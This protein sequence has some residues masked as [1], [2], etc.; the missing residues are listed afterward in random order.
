[1]LPFFYFCRVMGLPLVSANRMG[2]SVNWIF[3]IH[4]NDSMHG[5]LNLNKPAGLTS[6]D[7][8]ARLRKLLRQ[9]KIG[10]GGTLDPAAMGVLPIAIGKATRLLQ[11]L[12]HEK[13]YRATI[14][15]G[16]RTATDDLEGEVLSQQV[17]S[18]LTQE[19]VQSIL[20][21]FEGKIE[22]IPP[23]YSAIQVGG[24][25]LYELARAGEAIEAP[26]RTVEVYRIEVLDWRS[27]QFPELD[28]AIDCGTGTYIRSIARDLGEAVGTG[29]TLAKLLRTHSSGF[30]LA[31]SLT[32]E[33]VADLVAQTNQHEISSLPLISPSIALRHFPTVTLLPEQT[34]RWF[35][36]QRLLWHEIAH[37]IH[38]PSPEAEDAL[39]YQVH[40]PEGRF[41]GI[42]QAVRTQTDHW[43]QPKLVW[44]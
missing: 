43:L 28:V 42:G 5:F 36:G 44:E 30:Q 19:K 17:A 38:Y 1:M 20:P 22:Q 18:W 4:P 34:D 21:Q 13:A 9:K 10:H 37:A 31:E 25:R 40:H 3:A 41:L 26:M 16:M 29:G 35:R 2:G 6:H 14:R 8:V 11:Y 32:L 33:T 7:C 12:T 27:G 39:I 24:K 23:S 15:F